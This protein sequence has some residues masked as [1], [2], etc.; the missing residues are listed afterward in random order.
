M[1][2]LNSPIGLLFYNSLDEGE[3]VAIEWMRMNASPALYDKM[4]ASI[5]MFFQTVD[6]TVVAAD[7]IR[8]LCPFRDTG[9][10][11]FSLCCVSHK[12]INI[13]IGTIRRTYTPTTRGSDVLNGWT[14]W[15]KIVSPS[16]SIER[17]ERIKATD[18]AADKICIF[19]KN[20]MWNSSD[21]QTFTMTFHFYIMYNCTW[22][23]VTY[24]TYGGH[25]WE[26]STKIIK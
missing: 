16:A 17:L 18:F 15:R 20:L 24:V 12:I 8:Y 5:S 23:V 25:G 11:S 2:G 19:K 9:L 10:H 14:E 21:S 6:E 1:G 4:N 3:Y 22:Y 7:N 13:D 26:K